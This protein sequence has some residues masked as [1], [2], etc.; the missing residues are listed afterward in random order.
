MKNLKTGAI[1]TCN[2]FN[3]FDSFAIQLAYENSKT[4][5]KLYRVIKEGNYTSVNGFYGF[6]MRN[7]NTL[8]L[9]SNRKTMKE[10][11]SS[12]GIILARGDLVLVYPEQSM[13]FNYRKPRPMKDGAFNLAVKN[14]VPV[15]PMFITMK[16]SDVIG[17]DGQ[18]VQ[19][20]TINIMPPIYPSDNLNK[21]QNIEKLRSENESAWKA[22]YEKFYNTKLVYETKEN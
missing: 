7:C 6:L 10:F 4:K 11:L 12:V 2:H 13:W 1:I 22:V 18:P 14:N 3:P 15:V 5:R 16:D 9:S 17:P 8:P 20:Y 21:A 19:K